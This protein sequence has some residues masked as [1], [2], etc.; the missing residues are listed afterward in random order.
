[1]VAGGPVGRQRGS[2]KLFLEIGR[3]VAFEGGK[4]RVKF[5]DAYEK[6]G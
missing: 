2:D 5:K 3:C 6:T 4:E 1:M